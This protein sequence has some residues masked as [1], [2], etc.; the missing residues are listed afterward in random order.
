[1]E[2]KDTDILI[3]QVTVAEFRHY[4]KRLC[5]LCN[6]T[7]GDNPTSKNRL[8]R[9]NELALSCPIIQFEAYRRLMKEG[10]MNAVSLGHSTETAKI[11]KALYINL[12]GGAAENI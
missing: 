5:R 12:P 6:I 4:C 2:Y 10:G 7:N 9:K 3:S 1:M 8:H 11:I